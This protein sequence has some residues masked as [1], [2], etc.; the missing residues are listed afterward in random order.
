MTK[1]LYDGFTCAVIDE[2]EITERFPVVTDVKQGCCMSEFLFLLVIDWV[3]WKTVDGQR[4]SIRWDYKRLRR[5]PAATNMNGIP[6]AGKDS[7]AR[8]E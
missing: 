4:K 1:T 2:G 8:G 7:Q 6:H 5:R 3:M